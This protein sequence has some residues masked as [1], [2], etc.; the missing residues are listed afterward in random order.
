MKNRIAVAI[1][2]FSLLLP[3]QA[4]ADT[5]VDKKNIAIAS[6]HAW[7]IF[8][9]EERYSMSWNEASQ[10][11]KKIVRQDQWTENMKGIRHPL[12][13]LVSRTLKRSKYITSIPGAPDGEYV[14]IE[15]IT[16]FKE[17]KNAIETVTPLLD[18]DGKWRIS[19]YYIK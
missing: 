13:A 8:L 12:G 16:E 17:K 7:L 1:T 10:Y 5:T 19:G 18:K 3:I 4:L 6:A 15:F 2:L 11:F 14:V 9:D